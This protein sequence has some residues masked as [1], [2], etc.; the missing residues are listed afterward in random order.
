MSIGAPNAEGLSSTNQITSTVTGNEIKSEI[1]MDDVFGRPILTLNVNVARN[2]YRIASKGLTVTV[3][4][5]VGI[6]IIFGLLILR[7]WNKS[8]LSRLLHLKND[9][10]RLE[11]N[12]VMESFV[13]N[14]PENKDEIDHLRHE[15]FNMHTQVHEQEKTIKVK[16][17]ELE[18]LN[19][20][21]ENQVKQRTCELVEVNN[22]LFNSELNYRTMVNEFPDLI[23]RLNQEDV[24]LACEGGLQNQ[25]LMPKE[26]FLNKSMKE[27]LPAQLYEQ[28]IENKSKA[29]LSKETQE[30]E[31]TLTQNNGKRYY[32]VKLIPGNNEE[33][34]LFIA[35]ITPTVET[36]KH[37]EHLSYCDQLTGLYN[38]RFLE[39][40]F[41]RL[42]SLR[43]LPLTVLALDINGLKLVNDAFGHLSGDYLL[44]EVAKAI[45]GNLRSDDIVARVGGD[46]FVVLL[47]KTNEIIAQELA[48]RIRKD[49]NLIDVYSIPGSISIGSCTATVQTM[50][51]DDLLRLADEKMYAIKNHEGQAFRFNAVLSL[52]ER[53]IR[54]NECEK[55]HSD[56]VYDTVLKIG[57]KINLSEVDRISL[58]IAAKYHDIG[59]VAIPDKIILKDSALSS[60]EYEK[61]KRHSEIGY[62]IIKSSDQ[63]RHA[64]E[65]V[66]YHHEKWDGTGYPSGLDGG[67]IPLFSRII[68][69]ADAFESMIHYRPYKAQMTVAEAI[70]ELK[71]G[72]GKQFDPEVVK[73]L[74][75]V[76]SEESHGYL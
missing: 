44:K 47:P 70:T 16:Q 30:Y 2:L 13:N 18:S 66:L 75:E 74:F 38:R 61:V 22:R 40:E 57:R 62:Q 58:G 50:N 21:L 12:P 42:N 10:S 3:F 53:L 7:F 11:M 67:G 64:A 45:K 39:I 31:Y 24:F 25:L 1:L 76:L 49:V 68:H 28:F 14:M 8:V 48:N 72:A 60:E 27:V 9:V 23:F 17:M 54:S 65:S 35:D 69:V 6:M 26:A 46:E 33:V 52:Q 59:K 5:L 55:M 37:I 41:E 32:K 73:A 51:L 34:F 56:F 29:L 43:N 19:Q 63:L 15:I 20:S 71:K 4:T 36:I